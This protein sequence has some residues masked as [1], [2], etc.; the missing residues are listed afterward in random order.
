MIPPIT[1][2]NANPIR[3]RS[4]VTS[5]ELFRSEK[6]CTSASST[7]NGDGT[8]YSG[9]QPVHTM[10]CHTPMKSPTATSLGHVARQIRAPRLS[11]RGPGS[12]ASST[13]TGSASAVAIGHL[14]SQS[15]SDLG[16]ERGDRG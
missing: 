7:V 1:I 12:S 14:R 5:A 2:A 3:P 13:L 11:R 4:R 9:F 15:V 16:R 8:M 10:N 6:L